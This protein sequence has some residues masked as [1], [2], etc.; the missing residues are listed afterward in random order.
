MLE[1]AAALDRKRYHVTFALPGPGAL[2]AAL[3]KAGER[4]NYYRADPS[5]LKFHR[6]KISPFSFG[7]WRQFTRVLGA[8]RDLRRVI[9]AERPDLI[10]THSQKAHVFATL[11]R[12]GPGKPVIWHM[13]DVLRGRF[14]RAV[15]DL[16][17][18][19]GAARVVAVSNAVVGQFKLARRK[20][21]L[22]YNAVAPPES[23]GPEFVART[24]SAWGIPRDA[25]VVGCVGQIAPWK[26]Q[27]IFVQ[28]AVALAPAFPDL[29]FVVIGSSLYGA[30]A[31]RAELL[32]DVRRAGLAPRVRFLGQRED[33]A[34]VIGAFDVLVHTPVEPEPFGRVVVEAMARGVPVVAAGSGGVLEIMEDG[35]EGFVVGVG[36]AGAT[37]AAVA[38]L[39]DDGHLA[40]E[41]GVLGRETYKRRFTVERLCREVKLIYGEATGSG[42]GPPAVSV[43]AA[44]ILSA[45][46]REVEPPVRKE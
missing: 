41:M 5:L 37:A 26:G 24:K 36:D 34:A 35:R 19:F 38:F 18:A 33:A 45:P 40:A 30:R 25:R 2:A 23:L 10:H 8:A 42:I 29:Y 21:T 7:W 12:V 16:L 43:E 17:A 11:A 39:L 4:F 22:V 31:Y 20:V 46:V 9:A 28:A 27:H 14:A 1:L 15:M 6:E 13:R 3:E 44:S 32:R